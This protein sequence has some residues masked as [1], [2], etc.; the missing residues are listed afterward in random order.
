M[1]L[2]AKMKV[3]FINGGCIKP[4]EID[5][6]YDG[7]QRCDY[8]VMSWI[9]NSMKTRAGREFHVRTIFEGA[10]GRHPRKVC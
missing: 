2:G 3:G 10:V 1:A 9:I 7:W 4:C 5:D 8:M 6:D